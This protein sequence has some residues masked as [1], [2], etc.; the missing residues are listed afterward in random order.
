MYIYIY[1]YIGSPIHIRSGRGSGSMAPT[2][3]SLPPRPDSF[4]WAQTH[5]RGVPPGGLGAAAQ[6][7]PSISA[8]AAISIFCL[9]ISCIVPLLI[10]CVTIIIIINTVFI[11][12]C[13]FVCSVYCLNG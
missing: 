6:R 8:T 2:H 9:A 10:I 7:N 1:I 4:G 13:V 5:A 12:M 11:I 3:P